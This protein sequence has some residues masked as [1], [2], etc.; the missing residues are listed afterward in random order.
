L[1]LPNPA[2]PE[3]KKRFYLMNEFSGNLPNPPFEGVK[4]LN[5]SRHPSEDRDPVHC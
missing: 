4:K 5:F 3:P 1:P 2:K